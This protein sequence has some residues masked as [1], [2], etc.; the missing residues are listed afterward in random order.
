MYTMVC[1]RPDLTYLVSLVISFMSNSGKI[2]WHVIKY[3]FQYLNGSIDLG[4]Q[5]GKNVNIRSE[6]IG[7]VNS[8][9]AGNMDIRKSLIGFVFTVFGGQ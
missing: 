8:D 2:Y 9:Y 3:I 5:F 1:F 6:N 4:S 7:Y